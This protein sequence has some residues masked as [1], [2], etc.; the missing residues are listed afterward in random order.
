[1]SRGDLTVAQWERLEAVLPLI[2]KMGRPPRD[3]RQVFDGIWWRART[4]SPW[5]DLPERYGPWETAYAVFR[6]WQIDETWARVLKKLQVKADADGIIEWEVSR[7]SSPTPSRRQSAPVAASPDR[8]CTPTTEPSTRAEPSPEPAGQQVS[9]GS[10]KH[11]HGR[12]QR[13]QRTRRAFNAIFKRET[14]QGRKSWPNE[15]EA[16][17]DAFRRLHRYNT[18]RRHSRLGQRSPIA[19]E[20]AFHLAPTTLAPAA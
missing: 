8:S 20:N 15:R 12:V 5:R 4:G 9:R 1:M 19:F 11:E 7:T 10:T 18:R 13:G 16:R 17:L 2:P 3:R 14:P 6:R